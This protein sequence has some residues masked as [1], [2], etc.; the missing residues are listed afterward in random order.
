[1][2]AQDTSV[3]GADG[4]GSTA[5]EDDDGT[6]EKVG[7]LWRVIRTRLEQSELKLAR[8]KEDPDDIASLDSVSRT[9]QAC[10]NACALLGFDKL[11]ALSVACDRLV[12]SL[13]EGSVRMSPEAHAA[14]LRT[15]VAVSSMV[16]SIEKLGHEGEDAFEDLRAELSRLTPDTAA[17]PPA[18]EPASTPADAQGGT[19][20]AEAVPEPVPA[21]SDEPLTPIPPVPGSTGMDAPSPAASAPPAVPPPT[22]A[23]PVAPNDSPSPTASAPPAVPPPA[24]AKP[25]APNDAPSPTASAPSAVP[26]PAPAGPAAQKSPEQKPVETKAGAAP[27]GTSPPVETSVRVDVSLLDALMNQ[28]GELVLSRN[29]LVEYARRYEDSAFIASTQR[30]N[31]ITSELQE[32]VMKTR[33]QPIHSIWA[34]LPRVVRD[35]SRTVEKQIR[36]EMEG[37]ETELDKSLIEAMKDPLTHLL[38]NSV[39]H[40]IET[41]AVRVAKGKPAEGVLLLRAY[42]QGGQVHIE[43]QDDGAGINAERIC[44]KAIS[45]GLITAEQASNMSHADKCK[46]CFHPGLSTAEKVTNISGRG[47]GMDVVKTNIDAISGAID[48]E[49]V[50]GEGTT[51]KIRV[52]LTL[53]IVPALVVTSGGERFAIPQANLLELIRI[54]GSKE[55]LGV[56]KISDCPV[57]R[58]RGKLLPLV[59]LNEQLKLEGPQASTLNIVV[60]QAGT[61][62]FGLVVDEINESQEIVVKPLAE[63]IR[64]VPVFAGATIMG[65]GY[66]ALIIDVPGLA[67]RAHVLSTQNQQQLRRYDSE[68]GSSNDERSSLLLVRSSAGGRVAIPLNDI[69][70]L[71]QFSPSQLESV[72]NDQVVQ[73]RGQILPLIELSD[74]LAEGVLAT[75]DTAAEE[76]NVQRVVVFGESGRQVGL[77]VREIVDVVDES[78]TITSGAKRKGVLATAVIQGKVTEML[79]VSHFLECA[80]PAHSALRACA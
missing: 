2:P 40:G 37:K 63:V 41:P 70:R 1:M 60:L 45:K 3:S 13:R 26:P 31:Q 54:D 8:L 58:L 68:A 52:P 67:E 32:G 74:V 44:E 38:R 29:Q 47:V 61:G 27:S 30:L 20:A 9:V 69:S 39:D 77:V 33:M 75:A 71:E 56:E 23:E 72:G 25:V 5:A 14:L 4:P 24:P 48:L 42:H 78:L 22:P 66:L 15:V 57:Y 17:T 80:E 35:L 65:D 43:I 79:D 19:S 51:F 12:T 46:L 21:T 62:R 50:P 6:M 16:R 55:V 11:G 10:G 49:S 7:E 18:P 59:Y 34:K 28:V 53:A 64:S 76:D 36:V 73:Y